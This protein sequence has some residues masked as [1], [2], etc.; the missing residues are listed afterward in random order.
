MSKDGARNDG[1]KDEPHRLAI[2]DWI[3]EMGGGDGRSFHRNLFVTHK[4]A[5]E[6][7]LLANY[8][9]RRKMTDVYRTLFTYETTDIAHA[10]MMA[11]LCFDMDK[12]L[13]TNDDFKQIVRD[14]LLVLAYLEEELFIPKQ[15]VRIYFSGS[16]GF[17]LMVPFELTGMVPSNDLPEKYKIIADK[18]KNET[19]YRTVDMV[20]YERRRLFRVENTINSKTGLYKV[21][22]PLEMLYG[23]T[24][25]ALREYAS[26]PREIEYEEFL[27]DPR[28]QKALERILLVNKMKTMK[29]RHPRTIVPAQRMDLLPCVNKLLAEG[30]GQG[31][32]NNTCVAIASSLAQ[33]GLEKDEA[34]EMVLAWNDLNSPP[35][36]Q[37]EVVR[38][39]SSAYQMAHEGRGY[40][41]GFFKDNGHC[42]GE[43]CKLY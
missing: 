22:M 36:P 33:S 16:K 14:T 34:V 8:M 21:P 41:C 24:L 5:Y 39:V 31:G 29:R 42:I 40:G 9:E 1:Q 11:P 25:D 15:A 13:Y 4:E 23:L 12:E 26:I 17:H 35:L 37:A 30:T 3:V 32:R 43:Q 6:E 2:D 10:R 19:I 20:I 27:P 38:T 28:T 7:G 18:V